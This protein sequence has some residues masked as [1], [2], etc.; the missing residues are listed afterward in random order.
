MLELAIKALVAYLL[1]SII[2]SLV[3]GRF[4]GVDIRTQG[5][6]NAGGTN[7]LRT[8]GKGFAALVV[9]IDVGK[10]VLAATVVAAA[11]T[12]FGPSPWAP[13]AVTL[14]CGAAAIV[15]HVWPLFY[16]FRGGKGAATYIGV[17]A[18]G[19][20]WS[21]VPV[22]GVW[23]LS[24]IAS[25][26]VGLSTILA[27]W[28]LPVYAL[29]RSGGTIDALA[30]FGVAMAL[31]ITWTHRANVQRMLAGNENRFERAMLLRRLRG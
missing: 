4:K 28:A 17:L 22:L 5:S 10:G 1:G 6:G 20:P 8:Q 14:L 11:A 15:G 27:S 2:G 3:V 29:V 30:V 13:V 19:A 12:P 24:L 7:A 16:G 31:F 23:V 21:L 18:V 26:F 9:L 25:G